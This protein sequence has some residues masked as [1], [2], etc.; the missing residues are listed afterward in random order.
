[1]FCE[2]L[3]YVTDRNRHGKTTL[4]VV[5]LV[6][7]LG[8]HSSWGETV[9]YE[10]SDG[11]RQSATLVS[12]SDTELVVADAGRNRTIP[13]ARL[14]GLKFT[15]AGIAQPAKSGP[16]LLEL[17]DGS[18]L[19]GNSFQGKGNNWTYETTFGLNLPL[20]TKSIRTLR[21]RGLSTDA[22]QKGWVEAISEDSQSDGLIVARSSGELARV[23]GTIVEAKVDAIGFEFDDQRLEMPLEKLMGLA[24]FQPSLTRSAPPTMEVKFRDAS[25]VRVASGQISDGTCKF[26]L[27]DGT[28]ISPAIGMIQELQ[29]GATNLRWVAEIGTL[30]ATLASKVPWTTSVDL[31]KLALS[32]RFVTKS[33]F[34]RPLTPA[35]Q[36]LLFVAPGTFSFRMPEGFTRFEARVER[37]PMAEYRSLLTIEVLQ[38]EQVIATSQLTEENDVLSIKATV[39][40]EKKVSLVVRSNAKSNL[41]TEV[42]WKQPRVMR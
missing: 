9:E 21:F 8:P 36:D 26:K 12:M 16:M 25:N 37:P 42:I 6:L 35:E 27:M 14:N 34:G 5:I 3:C 18:K 22:Q 11:V 17:T 20:T 1:L 10:L 15:N 32:P 29:L 40:P 31:A 2:C 13:M 28:T 7:F 38:E 4:L 33:E 24:W 41:G 39:I 19:F 30:G 23:G